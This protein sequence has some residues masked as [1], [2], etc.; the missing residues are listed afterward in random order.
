MQITEGNL[1]GLFTQ[2]ST[3]YNEA[4]NA[5][6]AWWPRIGQLMPSGTSENLYS[7]M[8]QTP[9]MRKWIGDRHAQAL[10]N[11]IY[12]LENDPYEL[13]LTMDKFK[14]EDDRFG[15]YTPRIRMMGSAAKKWPDYMMV[16]T[17]QGGTGATIYDGQFFFDTDHPVNRYNASVLAPDGT[18]VQKNLF[19]SKAL[20]LDNFAD[21]QQQMMA[22]VGEDG[23]PLGVVPNLL[24]VPPQLK[25]KG[26]VVLN[27]TI[28]APQTLGGVTQVGSNSNVLQGACDMLVI[29]E[30]ANEPKVWYLLCTDNPIGPFIFQQRMAPELVPLTKPSDPN[31]S[32]MHEF[33][34]DLTARGATGYGV[35]WC[36]A[37][38]VE[39]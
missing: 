1:R 38:C 21:V 12:S 10:A 27:A 7:W 36:A 9:Q 22:W 37:R 5:K 6:T 16:A 14:L 24:V 33:R 8:Q 39:P 28:V 3:M 32:N 20:T 25:L 31:V 35:W 2:I 29:P 18:A 34:Y 4:Y 17:M 23:K 26:Q 15:I 30:L 11:Y 13:T 19:T